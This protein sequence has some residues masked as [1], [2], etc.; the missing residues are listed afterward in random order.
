MRS[1]AGQAVLPGRDRRHSG[2]KQS[3]LNLHHLRSCVYTQL[4]HQG[5][6][7][8]PFHERCIVR[9]AGRVLYD[10]RPSHSHAYSL[11]YATRAANRHRD[12]QPCGIVRYKYLA[13]SSPDEKQ[14]RCDCRKARA[15]RLLPDCRSPVCT[16]ND[17]DPRSIARADAPGNKRSIGIRAAA[18]TKG[19]STSLMLEIPIS[20]TLFR[21]HL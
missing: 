8:G 9:V 14:R 6:L 21:S 1:P 12:C 18:E 20:A 19:S 17:A 3:G 2:R 10:L 11:R 5:M 15:K 4:R 7:D 16:S 13:A